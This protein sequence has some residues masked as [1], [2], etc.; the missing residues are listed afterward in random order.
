M[1]CKT[2]DEIYK[3]IKIESISR[4]TGKTLINLDSSKSYSIFLIN[5]ECQYIISKN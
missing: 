2:A 1:V 4:S 5:N 3:F